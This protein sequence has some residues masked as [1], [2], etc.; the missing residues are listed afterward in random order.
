MLR[1]PDELKL[2]ELEPG[3]RLVLFIMF[4]SIFL[5]SS[6]F[7]GTG[8]SIWWNG[9]STQGYNCYVFHFISHLSSH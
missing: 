9:T 7:S 2:T 8:Q 1:G 5:P 3:H 6:L 4:I